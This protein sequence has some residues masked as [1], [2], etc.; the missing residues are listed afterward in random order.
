MT[1]RMTAL[2]VPGLALALLA[3]AGARETATPGVTSSS[4][5]LGSSGPLTGEAA[6]AGGVL[7][8]AEAY[9]KYVN[10]RGGVNGRR[11]QLRYYDDAGD[12]AKALENARRLV[13]EDQVF[14]LFSTVGTNGSLAVRPFAN[15][16]R[17]PQLFAS[18]GSTTLGRDWR[19]Y[20][21]TMGYPPA[22]SEEGQIYARY[23]LLTNG[24]KAGIAVLYQ[25]DAAGRELLAGLQ[26]GLGPNRSKI[27]ATV[28]YEPDATDVQPEV[29][30]LKDSGANTLVVF[31]FGR[32]ATQ[33]YQYAF[34]LGWRPQIYVNEAAA[35]SA[36]MKLL[37]RATAEGS[38]SIV[39]GK[40][41]DTPAFAEDPGTR[42][43]GEI[44]RRFVPGGNP[45]DGV[46]VAG[47]AS[48]FTMVDA[49]RRAGTNPTR[50]SLMKAA[51]SLQEANNPF[52]VP[53]VVVRTT[54]AS[55][56]P[57]TQVRLQRW[58]KGH[59]R[60]LGGLISGRP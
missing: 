53:G 54:P 32:F 18:S 50:E 38:I 31:A 17:V 11:I 20:P 19:Q 58:S 55:R 3:S 9:F 28:A 21:F 42:L 33:A 56:F 29:S 39:F 10:A 13:Q 48:A 22:Y 12:P 57:V 5:L 34:Q 47:M 51:T 46:L 23:L 35:A 6:A 60:L 15:A 44:V 37:P 40:D 7:R 59:W 25:D 30:E 4:I 24:A 52:L 1:K 16:S 8:G 49:L 14:A 43:A 2:A 41:P 27:V 45:R 26:K 36:T